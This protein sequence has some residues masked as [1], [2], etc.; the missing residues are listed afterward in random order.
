MKNKAKG[1]TPLLLKEQGS[2]NISFSFEYLTS[3]NEFNFNYFKDSSDKLEAYGSFIE[4]LIE[5]SGI[6]WKKILLSRKNVGIETIPY[7][8]IKFS[9]NNTENILSSDSKIFVI[10]FNKQK[11]RLLGFKKNSSSAFQI[12]GFDFNYSAYHH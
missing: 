7:H 3:N 2:S 8:E 12:I 1:K 11:Y 4:K 10:R 5:L 6:T 9:G